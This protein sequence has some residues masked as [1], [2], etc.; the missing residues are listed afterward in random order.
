M[1]T[2]APRSSSCFQISKL[3]RHCFSLSNFNTFKARIPSSMIDI[4]N[5]K[6]SSKSMELLH[7]EIPSQKCWKSYSQRNGLSTS[8]K[9]SQGMASTPLPTNECSLSSINSSL[10]PLFSV[11]DIWCRMPGRVSEELE[12]NIFGCLE[13][14]RIKITEIKEIDHFNSSHSV[15]T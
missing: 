8:N 12:L 1:G 7:G 9:P 15:V 10:V 3:H 6:V 11:V 2:D 13:S 14:N 5:R 4:S